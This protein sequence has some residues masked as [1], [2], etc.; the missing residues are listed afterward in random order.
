MIEADDFGTGRSSLANLQ[1][2]PMHE[3]KIDRAFVEG[4]ERPAELAARV[5]MGCDPVQDYLFARPMGPAA[6]DAR[7]GRKARKPRVARDISAVRATTRLQ[8][9]AGRRARRGG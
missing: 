5:E 9:S 7:C 6:F 3:P 8:E 4:V 1:R 2:L